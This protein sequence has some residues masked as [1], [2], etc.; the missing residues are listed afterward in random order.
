MS[1]EAPTKPKVI[2][3]R[4]SYRLHEKGRTVYQE[5]TEEDKAFTEDK[6]KEEENELISV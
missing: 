3:P 5:T 4:R 1:K 6:A 2:L